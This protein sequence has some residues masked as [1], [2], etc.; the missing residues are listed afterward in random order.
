[1]FYLSI[2][3]VA[4]ILAL[5]LTPVSVRLGL[6][7]GLVDRPG[8]RRKHAGVV[9]RTGGLAIFAAFTLT[10][11]ALLLLM[12]GALPQLDASWLPPQ[13][14]PKESRRFIALLIGGAFC[15]LAGFPR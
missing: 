12:S 8:E 2:L 7:L 9:P 5:I 10:V 3:L 13:D 6:R 1:M 4:L 11:F 15:A 14:D